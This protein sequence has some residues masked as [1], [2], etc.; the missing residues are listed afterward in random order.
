MRPA[1][2]VYP[3]FLSVLLLTAYGIVWRHAYDSRHALDPAT[4]A[5]TGKG[6]HVLVSYVFHP[7]DCPDAAE[8]IDVLNELAKGGEQIDGLM[9]TRTSESP[10]VR[11][12]AA[13]YRIRFPVRRLST[14]DAGLLLGALRH[15]RT[16]VAIVR[17]STGAIRMVIP[18][19]AFVPS[20]TQLRA[21]LGGK[22]A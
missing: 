4:P 5:Q 18:G 13:A 1:R 14:R 6:A 10:T 19:R 17:D 11:E 20:V 3:L 15:T 7:D 16:P 2:Q 8:F 12:I 21:L 9:V 22:S